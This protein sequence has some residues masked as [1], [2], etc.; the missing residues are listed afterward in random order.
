MISIFV[1]LQMSWKRNKKS[2]H[3]KKKRK[4]IH[5]RFWGASIYFC[6]LCSMELHKCGHTNK[7]LNCILVERFCFEIWNF[8]CNGFPVEWHN[9]EFQLDFSPF[10]NSPHCL[11]PDLNDQK[12]GASFGNGFI[13]KKKNQ[14]R[15]RN[16][17]TGNGN[18]PIYPLLST[19]TWTEAEGLYE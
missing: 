8:R 1:Y 9:R 5:K 10:Q 4:P 17:L 7:F 14:N 15:K 11:Y 18:N 12:T 19:W 3:E 16:P 2:M 13:F 6:W